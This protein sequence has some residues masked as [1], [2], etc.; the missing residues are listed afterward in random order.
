MRGKP[1]TLNRSNGVENNL[2]FYTD[3]KNVHLTLVKIAPKKVLPMK[4]IFLGHS[5]FFNGKQFPR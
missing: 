3:F 4:P 5:Q 2:S 1:F